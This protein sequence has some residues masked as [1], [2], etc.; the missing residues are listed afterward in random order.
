MP[1]KQDRFDIAIE[2]LA[3]RPN[4]LTVSVL[5]TFCCSEGASGRSEA[6][7]CP[8]KRTSIQRFHT[9]DAAYQNPP[10]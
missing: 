8:W 5:A 9:Y 2:V 4:C 6:C 1:G 3:S 10:L 7:A